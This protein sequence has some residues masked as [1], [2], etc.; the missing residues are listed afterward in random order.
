MY[1]PIITEDNRVREQWA[2]AA[3]GGLMLLFALRQRSWSGLLLGTAGVAL[4]YKS[5][6]GDN[7]AER[8]LQEVGGHSADGIDVHRTVTIRRTP[9]DVYRFWRRI[10]NLP[11]FMAHLESVEELGDGRS[12]WQARMPGPMPLSW[13]A[14]I[15]RDEPGKVLAW[16]TVEDSAVHHEG[17]VLFVPWQDGKGTELHVALSYHPPL[18]A[19]GKA[20]AQLFNTVTDQ[21]I[22]EEIRRCKQLLETGE[23]ATTEGQPSGRT[24]L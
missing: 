5:A 17:Q 8:L 16:E 7:P 10:E 4:L 6:T 1:D 2:A 18:G 13:E 23:I 11:R 20:V 22:K 12:R 21:Q 9:E 24:A 3:G 15:V 19:A 14:R